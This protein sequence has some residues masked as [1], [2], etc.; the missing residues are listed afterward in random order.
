MELGRLKTFLLGNPLRS[1]MASH[2]KLPK[3]K[4]LAVLSSDP[5]S[6]VAY[7][8]EEILI[9]LLLFSVLALAWSVPV[10]AAIVLL[11]VIVTLS[12]RQTIAAY[13]SG[14]GAYT[15]ATENLGQNA[16]LVAGASLMID[17]TLTVAVSV[18]AGVQ[19]I[20]SAF[21]WFADH[22]EGLATAIIFLIMV[23]NLRGVKESAS[24]FAYPAYFFVFSILTL[25]FV[26]LWKAYTGQ[27]PIESPVPIIHDFYPE[28]PLLLL[29]RAFSSGCAALTGIEAIS[30]GVNVFREPRAQNARITLA[31]MA[32][33]M[34][35]LFL[36][37]TIVMHVY[38]VLPRPGETAVSM[39]ARGVFGNSVFYYMVQAATVLILFL[40]ANTAYNGFPSVCSVLARDRYL[41][42]QLASMGDRLVFSN[43]IMG[44]SLGA[45][46]LV[47]LFKADTHL[48][49][50]LYAVGVFL[51]FT[52]SQA[53]MVRHHL[54]KKQVGWKK[55]LAINALGGITTAVV[56]SV[57][58]IT[59]FTHGAWMVAILIPAL[60]LL[61]K[62]VN[63]HYRW[64]A[65]QLAARSESS[66]I[67]L[68]RRTHTAIVPLSGLHPGVMKALRYA[69]SISDDVRACY[70]EL[71][72]EATERLQAQ[73]QKEAREIPFVVLK[74]PYRS[75]IRPVLQYIEDIRQTVHTDLITVVIPE[76][77][78][79]RWYHSFMH[80]QTAFMLRAALRFK[81]NTVIT[82]VRYHLDLP[83]H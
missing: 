76:F 5:L 75:V 52:L 61:F 32:F 70:V 25:I 37:M 31:W 27:A 81:R 56:L 16:G 15:V 6:S 82:S 53:G 64:V 78:T 28:L 80:N 66:P 12:Y 21:P 18:S 36:G 83:E 73:W 59:K 69:Q 35:V 65:S 68:G 24:I 39:L 2:E 43:G 13:P 71:D 41:P 40:A 67:A 49:I 45:V 17:Y 10:A 33:L 58:L 26:G 30:T 60:V 74:S 34:G 42:R 29:L 63:K 9:P 54:R 22:K 8:T 4:A 3:W 79:P 51:S 11:L 1:E 72:P 50:P 77:V 55:G 38:G 19:N 20:A 48:L 7:A 14:G 57:I 44:L 62:N 46:I 47:F 23:L